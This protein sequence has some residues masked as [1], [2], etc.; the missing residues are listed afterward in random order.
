MPESKSFFEDMT[1][2]QANLVLTNL[3]SVK[4][5]GH[6]EEKILRHVAANHPMPVFDFFR[7]RLKKK[8]D[9]D[10]YY[11]AIPFQ[12]HDLE[13]ELGKDTDLAIGAVRNWYKK[14]DHMFQFTGG[15]LLHALYPAFTEAMAESLLNLLT[16]GNDENIDFCLAVLANYR[17]ENGVQEVIMEIIHRVSEQDPRMGTIDICLSNTG[18]VGG[19]FGFVEAYRAKIAAIETWKNDPRPKVKKFAKSYIQSMKQRI[20]SEQRQAEIMKEG[21]KRD[22]E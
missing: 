13:R 22:Y 3:R 12:F 10:G 7:S 9:I 2:A 1:L 8:D 17:G 11:E 14:G 6:E 18:V 19:A 21:R 5:I 20:A 16:G 15:R 4:K